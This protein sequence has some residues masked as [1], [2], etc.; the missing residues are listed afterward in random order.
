MMARKNLNILLTALILGFVLTIQSCSEDLAE[1]SE[2]IYVQRGK[3]KMPVYI[4]G[5][6]ESKALI[7][8]VHGGPGGNGYEYR[9]G[10]FSEILE[11]KYGM[12]YWDQRGQGMT[13]GKFED[14]ELSIDIM[15]A[16][17]KAVIQTLKHKYGDDLSIFLLGHSWGGTLGSAFMVKD[18][19]QDLVKGWIESNGAHDIPRLNKD[20]I[21]MF[22]RVAQEQIALGQHSTEWNSIMDWANGIDT[23]NITDDQG[24]EINQKG[25]EVEGYLT[26]DGV[27]QK[28]EEVSSS[29]FKSPI[30]ALTSF[31]VGNATSNDLHNEVE[32]TAL[33]DQ[34]HKI[35]TPTLLL[36]GKYD[37]V[38]PPTL[39]E[40]AE[41][42]ISSADKTLVIFE[43][44]GHSPMDNEPVAFTDSIIQFV[45]KHK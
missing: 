16:D 34:L 40:D 41:T 45:E 36:W 8:V 43:K 31:M 15:V 29:L 5:N 4:R 23:N 27:I 19:N 3:V 21:A 13:M 20:A 17:L 6:V 1:V 25:F 38:V 7:L 33:T 10:K 24:T 18:D 9:A 26:D 44:S 39:G 12:A 22:K 11:E 32:N 35:T 30:N 37:F 42:E 28:G 2:T 14:S